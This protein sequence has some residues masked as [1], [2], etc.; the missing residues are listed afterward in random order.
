[1]SNSLD[2][3]DATFAQ[4]IEQADVPTLVDF[5]A[6]WCGPCRLL[7]PILDRVSEQYAGRLRVVRVNVDANWVTS[8]RYAIRSI[9][10]LILFK[11]GQPVARTVGLVRF[12]DLTTLLDDELAQI[13]SAVE[14]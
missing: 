3:T 4:S 11:N 13:G 1:M 5:W 8:D 7:A 9:P 2:A 6:P 14:G 10:T 12:S